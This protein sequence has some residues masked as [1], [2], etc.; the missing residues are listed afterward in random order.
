M[1]IFL[2]FKANNINDLS[3]FEVGFDAHSNMP[4]FTR[5]EYEYPQP[6]VQNIIQLYDRYKDDIKNKIKEKYTQKFREENPLWPVM[7]QKYRPNKTVE[8]DCLKQLYPELFE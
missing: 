5:W 8:L 3:K 6:T 1:T 4:M 7:M 2:V